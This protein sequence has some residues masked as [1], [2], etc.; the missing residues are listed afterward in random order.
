[1]ATG[2]VTPGPPLLH[3]G[4]RGS[5]LLLEARAL[6]PDT[7][8]Y[9][10]LSK[11][12]LG[13]RATEILRLL[14]AKGRLS[15][16]ELCELSELDLKGVKI[17]LVSLI[18][19]RC[20][21]FLE[22]TALSG[23]KT[24]Y[25]YFHEVGLFLMLYAG[26]I[27]E[28]IG[29]KFQS[30]LAARIVQN[31]LALGSLTVKNYLES[32]QS[33]AGTS[34]ISSEFVR[35]CETGFLVPVRPHDNTTEIDLWTKLY[36]KEYN[37]IPKTSTLSDLKKRTE[38]R[39]KAKEQ[40]TKL[41]QSPDLSKIITI[42]NRTSLREVIDTVP[43]SFNLS[44]YLKTKRSTHLFHFASSRVGKIPATIYEYALHITE[45]SSPEVLHPLAKTGLFQDLDELN[46]FKE[47]QILLEEK[48]P[49]VTFNAIDLSKHLPQSLDLRGTL[50]TQKLLKRSKSSPNETRHNKKI[51][52]ED[53]FVVPQLPMGATE[54]AGQVDDHITDED[55]D[56]SDARGIDLINAHLK[57][58]ASSKIPFLQEA[59]PGLYYVPYSAL[60]PRLKSF[61]YDTILSSTL[62]PSFSR[63]LRCVKEH[64]LTTEKMINSMVLMKEKDIRSVIAT[65]IKY[66][67]VEIQE[68]PRTVDRAASRSVFLFRHN[69]KHAFD[70]MKHN[71]TWNMA[72]LIRK[73]EELK[74]DNATLLTKANRE[75]VKGKERELLLPSEIN[76]L[77][78]VNEGELNGLT[79]RIRIV[80]IWE[81]FEFY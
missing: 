30:D 77:K 44:R 25:Y 67:A 32:G 33:E 72:N 6:N 59:Q 49:G 48:T 64:K 56:A 36:K 75:D 60:I 53:G 17:A 68:V 40:F 51:K 12:H 35:L 69:E 37:N 21:R 13:E 61:T 10:E 14:I 3:D 54:N 29:S 73:T 55:E 20:V 23:R 4:E 74:T 79:R 78:M 43:L 31:V 62:G 76:Q 57:L 1:M 15:A 26:E 5:A 27:V 41:Y 39:H 24:T 42:N 34:E 58:L 16:R 50:L 80:S 7:F 81:I 45:R 63:V 66:N 47:E 71:L 46:A 11:A 9:T 70:M 2:S 65:L 19:L 52:T 28:A 22:E 38:A 8:L 18:Q